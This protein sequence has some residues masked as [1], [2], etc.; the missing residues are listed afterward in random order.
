MYKK[1]KMRYG[2]MKKKKLKVKKAAL[3]SMAMGNIKMSKSSGESKKGTATASAQNIGDTL[4]KTEKVKEMLGMAGMKTG[5][6]S[7]ARGTG[8]AI[9]GTNFKGIF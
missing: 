4:G 3:G 6:M 1:N 8:C 5:G 2:G 7:K 9:R